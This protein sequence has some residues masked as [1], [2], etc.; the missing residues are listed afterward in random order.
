M[1]AARDP[2]PEAAA[3]DPLRTAVG[4]GP[5]SDGGGRGNRPGDAPTPWT[6]LE[7]LQRQP[8]LELG[9]NGVGTPAWPHE[10]AS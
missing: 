6:T 9:A 5:A 8:E 10:D 4:E 1:A 2:A 7:D 3:R